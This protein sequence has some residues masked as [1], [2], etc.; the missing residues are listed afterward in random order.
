VLARRIDA[1]RPDGVAQEMELL[2]SELKRDESCHQL[3]SDWV[4]QL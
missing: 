4:I 3:A 2:R 1:A